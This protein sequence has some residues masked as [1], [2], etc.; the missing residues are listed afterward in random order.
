[1]DHPTEKQINNSTLIPSGGKSTDMSPNDN[2]NTVPAARGGQVQRGMKRKGAEAGETP[3]EISQPGRR[4][5]STSCLTCRL[6][7]RKCD[8]GVPCNSVSCILMI[9]IN[10]ASCFY[11][12]SIGLTE[13]GKH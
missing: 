12:A 6:K 13:D 3:T 2:F 1:M 4:Q 7:K 11:E 9:E 5:P 10:I 8:R